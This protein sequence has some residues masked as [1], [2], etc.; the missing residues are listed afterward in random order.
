MPSAT[1]IGIADRFSILDDVRD[2][3]NFRESISVNGVT[4]LSGTTS[5]H[6]SQAV[7][8][9]GLQAGLAW[10]PMHNWRWLRFSGGYTF[11]QWWDVGKVAGS[12]ADLTSQGLFLRTELHF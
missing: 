12:S 10:T 3:Q 8:V 9:L 6:G 5:Q 11:E 2:H 1:R 7:P 4:V